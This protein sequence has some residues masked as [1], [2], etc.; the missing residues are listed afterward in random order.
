MYFFIKSFQLKRISI[1]FLITVALSIN[2]AVY[3]AAGD[4]DLSFKASAYGNVNG[5]VFVIKK[6]IDEKILV[7]GIFTE[8]D[9]YA[10]SGLVRFNSDGSVDES[11]YPPDF[12]SNFGIGATIFAIG[13]QSDGKIIVGGGLYGADGVF[14]PGLKRLN[15]D[16]SLD[17]TFNAPQTDQAHSILDIEI[18]PDDKILIG[19][20]FKLA[21]SRIANLALLN[22]DG[23]I[24]NT[25]ATGF[26]AD[27][28]NDLEVQADG[29]IIVAGSLSSDDFVRRYSANGRFQDS[30]FAQ[31]NA[32]NSVEVVKLQGD[33]KILIGGS[34]TSVNNS[35]QGR[36]VRVNTDGTLDLDFNLNNTEANGVVND[37]AV[38]PNGKII[39]GGEFTTYGTVAR[40]KLAQLNPDGRLDAS[41]QDNTILASTVVNDIEIISDDKILVG[42]NSDAVGSPLILFNADGKVDDTF[43]PYIARIG[44][45]R[46]I[47]Q[48]SN[49][50]I[51]IAGEFP[52]VNGV[53]RKSLARL[54]PN[55]S[56]DTSF[57]PYFN[58]TQV[59]NA[60]AAQ[61]DG[62]ILVGAD[63]GITLTRLNADGSLDTGFA[64]NLSSA[65]L[66]KDVIVLST[67]QILAAGDIIDNNQTIR[68]IAKFNQDGSLDAGLELAQP[69]NTV[70]KILQQPDDRILIGGTFTQIG[71]AMR[72]R[73][74][75]LFNNGRL[76]NSFN[77]PGG[78]NNIVYDFDLQTDGK[79]VLG[80][81][82]TT[83]NGSDNQRH[84]GR[85][86]ADGS[87][88][89]A[90]IQQTDNTVL[91]V[92]AQPDGKILIGGL[93]DFVQGEAHNGIARLFS[94]GALDT[95][96]NTSANS[97]VWDI[98]LQSDG[99]IL[100]GG[101]FSKINGIS[102]VRVARLTNILL[103]RSVLFDY[104]GDGRADVS[105]YRPSTNRW[106][107]FFIATSSVAEQTFGIEGDVIAPAD[108]DGDGKTDLGI[109]RPSSGDWWYLSSVDNVEK[110]VRF[111]SSGDVPRP[112]DFDGD[113]K[114]DF[115]VF[116]PSNN[117]WYRFG[118]T[119]V[120]TETQFG[121][122]GDKP[123]TGDF[124][125]DGK[126]DLAIY[127]PS[128]GTWWYLASTD[129]SQ[130][131]VRF[132]IATDTPVA[133][134]Y[135]GDGR[136]DFAV[137]RASEGV[138]YIFNSG[139]GSN[140][141]IKFGLAED[142][143]VAA[144]YDGDGRA[145]IAV[146]RPSQGIWYLL[147]SSAGFA[148]IQFG[149][150]TDIPTP[151]AFVP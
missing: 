47:L 31:V 92:K 27:K 64:P 32:N 25:F 72:G 79:I 20:E 63:N 48:L 89:A 127:R 9:G 110:S 93:F 143:P 148:A 98:N 76:D 56:L 15:P 136:T 21:V 104:D 53:A 113:G 99:K 12:F 23:T 151:N 14:S 68:R 84:I 81:A 134:D 73:I 66:I 96:F 80:G 17:S 52:F 86:N 94:S 126:S 22:A 37:I 26:D 6:Q 69:N 34:F 117:F 45:V 28:I 39:I 131:A 119:G 137:Y 57:V 123:V 118:S 2:F 145:D 65:S 139:G 135:D 44:R 41:F 40:Q 90:F 141:I 61:A 77:P 146:F 46:E 4:V 62:K 8:V 78:A 112:S 24:D 58:T 70:Y 108:Y 116:R 150:S 13:I 121:L 132:G 60:V 59:I 49:G 109:F 38:R 100:L 103:P 54:N 111:G 74:A 125:G 87:L 3:G 30:S 95:T 115:I 91:A 142:K 18:L 147:Q 88:D 43:A 101:A 106:F 50:K 29:K 11:F 67:G 107:E 83:L 71:P 105:V 129:G 10:R 1:V 114:A 120:M 75:R 124:D 5:N 130:R 122:D 138:W 55:G 33:G 16:G 35:E 140:T 144:D 85:L 102:S 42:T 19:G 128:T 7:G 149:V 36:I 97:S 133:A 82:F 51:L